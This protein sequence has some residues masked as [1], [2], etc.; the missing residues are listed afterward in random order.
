MNIKMAVIATQ[1]S[2][3][4]PNTQIFGVDAFFS[5]SK[6]IRRRRRFVSMR[7]FGVDAFFSVCKCMWGLRRFASMRTFVVDVFWPIC[8]CM[9]GRRRFASMRTFGVDDPPPPPPPLHAE[10][11]DWVLNVTN[12]SVTFSSAVSPL[13]PHDT[14]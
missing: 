1:F 12:Q 13:P 5:V 4:F 9:W 7:T 3:Y 2:E 11:V 10:P 6:N 8:K 14:S